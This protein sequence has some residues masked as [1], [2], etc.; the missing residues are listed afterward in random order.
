MENLQK[1]VKWG[2]LSDVLIY[3]VDNKHLVCSVKQVNQSL[4]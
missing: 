1:G 2:V 3:A 4:S